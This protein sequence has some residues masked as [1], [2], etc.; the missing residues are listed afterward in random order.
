MAVAKYAAGFTLVELVLT[1]VI[2][3]IAGVSIFAALSF[4]L[5]HQSDGMEYARTSAL[6]QAYL[7][8]IMAKKYDETTPLGGVP[9]CS[10]ST[11]A[12]SASGSFNDGEARAQ[13]DDVDDYDGLDDLPPLHVD[14]SVRYEYE[15]F[16]VQVS[17]NYATTAQIAALGLAGATDAKVVVVTVTPPAASPTSFAVTR[18]NF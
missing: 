16:R 2:I 18:T 8:E 14:G 4:N 17:V 12:C 1:I 15:R 13:F 9:P 11:T 6:A 3:S 10:A 7:E 5:R